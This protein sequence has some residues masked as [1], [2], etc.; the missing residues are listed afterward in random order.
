[1]LKFNNSGIFTGYLKQLLHDFKL[2]Q[3]HIYT[4]ENRDY[5]E[6]YGKEK[7]IIESEPDLDPTDN[8]YPAHVRNILYLKDNRFQK[9]TDGK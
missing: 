2:P 1:M 9:Y 3:Y 5:F 7:N 6:K 8:S 4:K